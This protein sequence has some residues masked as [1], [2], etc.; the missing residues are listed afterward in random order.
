MFSGSDKKLQ[1]S[2]NW[3]KVAVIEELQE[4]CLSLFK[5]YKIY[6]LLI[7]LFTVLKRNKSISLIK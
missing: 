3:S 4:E 2:H 5:L 1:S 6:K 7:S